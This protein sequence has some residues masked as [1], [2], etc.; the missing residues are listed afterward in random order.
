MHLLVRRPNQQRT[1]KSAA[2]GRCPV[3]QVQYNVQVL[4]YPPKDNYGVVQQRFMLKSRLGKL[5]VNTS[6]SQYKYVLVI[7]MAKSF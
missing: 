3:V 6:I 1:T 5:L 2:I 7:M 4:E